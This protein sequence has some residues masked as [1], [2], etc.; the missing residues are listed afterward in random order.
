MSA[1]ISTCGSWRV[2][3]RGVLEGSMDITVGQERHRLRGG[4]CLAMQLDQLTMFHNPTRKFSRYA[5]VI[6]SATPSRR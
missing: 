5:V 4:D 6:A 2:R 3:I 1:G